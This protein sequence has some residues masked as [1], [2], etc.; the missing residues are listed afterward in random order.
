VT[1]VLLRLSQGAL[2]LTLGI[3]A[4]PHLNAGV[5]LCIGLVLLFELMA[6]ADRTNKRR[7]REQA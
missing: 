5:A 3:A 4:P 2:L 1:Q 7:Q 6:R